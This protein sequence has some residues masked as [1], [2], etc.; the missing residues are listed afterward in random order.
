LVFVEGTHGSLELA[1]NY[2]VRLTTGKGTRV[3]RHAPPRYAWADPRYEVAQASI[4]PCCA[5]LV[6]GLRGTG[7]GE[8]T[9][10]DNLKT[11]R[12]VFAAYDSARTDR[13]M[14]F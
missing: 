14:T 3:T 5:D 2:V 4:V 10:E 9:G 12:L 8:T 6:S 11:L 7:G 1:A 13:A